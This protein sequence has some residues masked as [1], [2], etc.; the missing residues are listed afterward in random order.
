MNKSASK[1]ELF[2][3][4]RAT[5]QLECDEHF[6]FRKIKFKDKEPVCNTGRSLSELFLDEWTARLLDFGD[7]FLEHKDYYLLALG[8]EKNLYSKDVLR[9]KKV[10]KYLAEVEDNTERKVF[11][12]SKAAGHKWSQGEY[13][14]IKDREYCGWSIVNRLEKVF[15][16]CNREPVYVYFFNFML[17]KHFVHNEET[18]ISL[19]TY[20]FLLEAITTPESFMKGAKY[21]TFSH[22]IYRSFEHLGFNLEKLSVLLYFLYTNENIPAFSKNQWLDVLESTG[23]ILQN[24]ST[25]LELLMNICSNNKQNKK[26]HSK[27]SSHDDRRLFSIWQEFHELNKENP[28]YL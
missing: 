13:K 20:F 21:Q 25:E 16:I 3:F 6:H 9:S 12:Q 19:F 27:P 28:F 4:H 17:R 8:E 15:D 2:D 14:S 23:D 24:N 26:N 5:E 22:V 11:E 7:N 1:Y 10:V 18:K